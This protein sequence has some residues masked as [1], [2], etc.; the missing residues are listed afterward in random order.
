MPEFTGAR[1]GFGRNGQT[2]V[3]V[4][5]NFTATGGQITPG[6]VT[7]NGYTYHIFDS[8]NSPENFVVS[9]AGDGD[10]L[11]EVLL[12]AGGGGGG[13]SG[14]GGGAGGVRMFQIPITAA[15]TMPV[16]VG[17]GGAGAPND[18]NNNGTKGENSVLVNPLG[19]TTYTS[20][21]GGY[22]GKKSSSGGPGGS[23]GG[24]GRDK[25]SSFPTGGT[26]S[27]DYSQGYEGGGSHASGNSAGGGGG[28]A[29][30]PGE[31]GTG[32]SSPNEV[33]G[34]GGS[35]AIYPQFGGP[36]ISPPTNANPRVNPAYRDGITGVGFY[37]AGGCGGCQYPGSNPHPAVGH[38]M[39]VGPGSPTY[40]AS[41]IGGRGGSSESPPGCTTGLDFTGSGGGGGGDTDPYAGA[42]GGKGCCIIRYKAGDTVPGAAGGVN[43]GLKGT[44]GSIEFSPTKVIHY[45]TQPGTFTNTS[46]SPITSATVL[47]VGGGGAGGGRH[48]GGGGGGGVVAGHPNENLILP[49]SPTTYTI[50]VGAGGR[51]WFGSDTGPLIDGSPSIIAHPTD[52]ITAPGG[53]GGGT[54]PSNRDGR[55]GG[56]GGGGAGGE[57]GNPA[58]GGEHDPAFNPAGAPTPHFGGTT[59]KY[60]SDGGAGFSG[61][62]DWRNGGG[63]GGATGEGG[64]KTGSGQPGGEGGN[65]QPVPVAG[66]AYKWGGGGGGSRW[67]SGPS[68][69]DGGNGGPG[70]GGVGGVQP[71]GPGTQKSGGGEV[72]IGPRGPFGETTWVG[73]SI[74]VVGGGAGASGVTGSGGGGGG[75]GQGLPFNSSVQWVQGGP[76]GPGIVVIEYPIS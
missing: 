76:G 68:G 35:G 22:G 33:A 15:A 40:V 41:G 21:G 75:A 10:G 7:S 63:G 46:G 43:P 34:R 59:Y 72:W 37:G 39:W 54:W 50:T 49:N 6:D 44:G 8:P 65:G 20:Y 51:S 28:G 3:Q 73:G 67:N 29:T 36:I 23:A 42:A 19:P 13:A 30:S 9:D 60:G 71:A 55:A 31:T 47:V 45:F 4:P 58:P 53:G 11:I 2:G 16:T 66:T 26:E 64:E 24:D 17:D 32:P 57:P 70:G 25:N 12:V 61:P 48:G 14:G 52:T 5:S 1:F 56:S 38:D 27:G 62:P 69:G 18:V 74:P